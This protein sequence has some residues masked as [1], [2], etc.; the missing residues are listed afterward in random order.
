MSGGQTQQVFFGF[1]IGCLFDLSCQ[2]E[3][4]PTDDAVFDQPVAGLCDFLFFLFSLGE[5]SWVPDS[6]GAG[7]TV[8]KFNLV[9]LF[10]DGLSQGKVVDVA[11]DEDGF[12]DLPESFHRLVQRVLLGI[13]IQPPEDI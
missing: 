12:D 10:F 3:I 13:G 8:G 1:S 5:L 6:Y 2:I 7:E 11:Q 4:I 9:E